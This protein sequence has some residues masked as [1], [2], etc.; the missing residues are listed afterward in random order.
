MVL[1]AIAIIIIIIIIN[2]SYDVLHQKN[3]FD[4][5]HYRAQ[6]ERARFHSDAFCLR[7]LGEVIMSLRR[8]VNSS[9]LDISHTTVE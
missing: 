1:F 2:Q 6:P 8:R 9:W 4:G 7:R 5:E 3:E